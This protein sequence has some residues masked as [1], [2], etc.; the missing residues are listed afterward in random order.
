MAYRMEYVDKT[1]RFYHRA[2]AGWAFG[3]S[4]HQ[5]LQSF[6]D[7]GGAESVSADELVGRLAQSWVS[8]GYSSAAHE[9]AHIAEAEAILGRYHALAAE[10]ASVKTFATEAV[11]RY[12]MGPFVLTGRIDRIDEHADGTLEV[13]DYKSGRTGV[14]EDDVRLSVAMEIYQLLVKRAHPDRRVRATIHGL[15]D[16]SSATVE[17]TDDELAAIEDDLR[18]VG[19]EIVETDFEA[20]R[21][22]LIVGVCEECDFLRACDRYWK[23]RGREFELELTLAQHC[24]L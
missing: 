23:A 14:G 21:P 3:T 18:G 7:A 13:V 8:A 24:E 16:G 1:G 19:I 12:D 9:D 17:L 11:L 2:R 20:V 6:H 5:T 15:Q 4:L 10:R 22:E